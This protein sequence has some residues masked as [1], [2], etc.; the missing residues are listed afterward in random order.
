VVRS[1]RRFGLLT[2][3]DAVEQLSDKTERI[4]LVVVPADRKA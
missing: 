1:L 3:G 2:G 4:D